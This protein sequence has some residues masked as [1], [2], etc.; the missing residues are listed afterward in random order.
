MCVGPNWGACVG[1]TDVLTTKNLVAAGGLHTLSLGATMACPDAGA[2]SNVCDPYCNYFLDTPDGGVDGGAGS[3]IVTDG[4]ITIDPAADGGVT[5]G[6]GFSAPQGGVSG[7]SPNRN[8]VGPNCAVSPLTTCQQDFRCDPATQQCVWNG[9][10]AYYNPA[11]AGVDLTIESPCGPQGSANSSAVV[12]NRGSAT[13][14]AGA[15]IT[16]FVSTG[17][18]P[19]NS[20][21]NLGAPTQTN[22]LAS[23]LGAGQCTSFTLS[24]S[25]GAKFIT[26]NAGLPGGPG[27]P[28]VTE[29]A[30]YCANNSAYW[31]TDGSGGTCALCNTC[32]TTLTGTIYDPGGSNVLPDVTV[33]VPSANPNALPTGAACDTCASLIT[34]TPWSLATT[35]YKGNFSI[36]VPDTNAFPL[37]IQA[38]RWRRRLTIPG[39][40]ACT[41]VSLDAFC[42]SPGGCKQYNPTTSSYSACSGT[43]IA[44]PLDI[45]QTSGGNP[46]CSRLPGSS[47]EG[48]LPT[49]ALVQAAGDQLEC[50]MRKI[51]VL[52]SEFTKAG[53]GGKISLFSHNGMAGPGGETA[54][55]ALWGTTSSPNNSTFSNY[56][57]IISP[58]DNNHTTYA[59][60]VAGP[61]TN[62]A[63]APNPSATAAQ[64]ANMAAYLNAGG[65]LFGSHWFAFD[66][67]QSNYTTAMTNVFG[68]AVDADREGPQF[69]FTIDQSTTTGLLF[70]NWLN[71]VGASPGGF[72]TVRFLSWRHLPQSVNSP[73]T[74][75]LAYGDS[76][77]AP[78]SH[79]PP[80]A[81]PLVAVYQFNTP[82]GS[83]NPCGR[84]E[85]AMSHVSQYG[86]GGTFPGGCGWA[87]GAAAPAMTAQEQSFEF[88]IFNSQQCQGLVPTVP[89]PATPALPT[90]TFSRD[91]QGVCPS[92]TMVKWGV[93]Y[94]QATIPGASK[95]NFDA[96][97]ADTQAGLPA[98][99]GAQ[100]T[101]TS[102]DIGTA[103]T[104]TTAPA[105]NCDGCP[106]APV[107]VDYDL[108]HDIPT[109]NTPSKAWLRV[110]MTF[111]PDN[112][113]NP[114]GSPTLNAWR[115]TYDCV[116][117]E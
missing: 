108:Q 51:G 109:P 86:T 88:L 39:I 81:G 68:T 74:L 61:S 1:E 82:Y 58:C 113:T 19:P 65:R 60:S 110:F 21:T 17:S 69:D 115:Q 15:S 49:M 32:V 102:R 37:V 55:S 7:C 63:N 2:L 89:P 3:I 40:T 34:G 46:T 18:S 96:A 93:F 71:Y 45:N 38:G 78:V 57:A 101:A 11:V 84:V 117:S 76:S 99:P 6:G 50:L 83:A 9:N 94:W 72:G 112:T 97:T 13:L 54:E 64:Q 80:A 5:G 30:G 90:V 75:R 105:W 25:T 35:D 62:V 70:A 24:N 111:T 116:P 22:T 92:G 36:T 100:P 85:M 44:A 4:G 79:S 52:D 12:C 42:K 106:S 33:Y 29:A 10:T 14:A 67:L 59:N 16:F 28:A 104:T 48:D 8:I 27:A 23:A 91:Y 43:G 66:W 73:N 98:A 20:C 87:A 47:A 95:I 103:S 114:P 41:T 31:R 107:S 26:V 53:G 56:A 77:K